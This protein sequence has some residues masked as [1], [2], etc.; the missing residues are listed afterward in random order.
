MKCPKCRHELT[1]TG[2][3]GD[4]KDFICASGHKIRISRSLAERGEVDLADKVPRQDG[5]WSVYTTYS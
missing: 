1:A 2:P 5:E 3:R 4:G